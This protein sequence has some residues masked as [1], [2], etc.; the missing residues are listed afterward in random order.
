MCFLLAGDEKA[1]GLHNSL[2]DTGG[3]DPASQSFASRLE[4]LFEYLPV[5]AADNAQFVRDAQN[6]AMRAAH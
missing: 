5:L 1:Q 3:M 6:I 4:G 2:V